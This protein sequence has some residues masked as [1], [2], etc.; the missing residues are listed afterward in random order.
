MFATDE[1][2]SVVC[3]GR[4]AFSNVVA[5]KRRQ[6]SV[7]FGRLALKNAVIRND[8]QIGCTEVSSV[9]G[10]GPRS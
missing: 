1:K 8:R 5:R 3:T 10:P 7:R 2:P 6:I 4:L 9:G